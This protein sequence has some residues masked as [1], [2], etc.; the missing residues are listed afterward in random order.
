MLIIEAL[1]NPEYVG[2]TITDTSSFQTSQFLRDKY[3]EYNRRF[4]QGRLPVIPVELLE[5]SRAGSRSA[6]FE[7]VPYY[8]GT[9]TPFPMN[10]PQS[11]I[12]IGEAELRPI[13]IWIS[14][15]RWKSRFQIE[16]VLIHEMCH[17]CQTQVLL[18]KD[19]R[20]YLDDS[21]PEP[22]VNYGGHGAMFF[23]AAD[24]FIHESPD[25]FE[26]FEVTQFASS[27]EYY[28]ECRRIRLRRRI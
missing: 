16:N 19:L 25:N 10:K 7:Q 11:F 22:G 24:K 18:G 20:S 9:T 4:F 27:D 3:V 8:C 6:A 21:I 13:K 28:K 2:T 26:G 23:E 17:V 5:A 15:R 14:K 1:G 12:R